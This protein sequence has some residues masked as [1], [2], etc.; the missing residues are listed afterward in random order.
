[1]KLSNIIAAIIGLAAAAG[2]DAQYHRSR[3]WTNCHSA[4]GG[5]G[6]EG[7]KK[8]HALFNELWGPARLRIQ[9]QASYAV[10]CDGYVFGI[11]N[12]GEVGYF[13]TPGERTLAALEDTGTASEC[14]WYTRAHD[15]SHY[16]F[17]GREGEYMLDN[18]AY[19]RRC[20]KQY[21]P[22]EHQ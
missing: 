10:L 6:T 4:I 9:H 2:V 11:A 21:R 1:M 7:L 18:R 3:K 13:E 15:Y 5:T 20:K 8:V 17:F 12:D 16:Y 14:R 19:I 22:W